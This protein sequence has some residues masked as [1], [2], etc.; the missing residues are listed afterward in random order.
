MRTVWTAIALIISSLV[1]IGLHASP[2]ALI[3]LPELV[4]VS[5]LVVIGQTKDITIVSN[6]E[7]T[8]QGVQGSWASVI[9]HPLKVIKGQTLSGDIVLNFFIPRAPAGYGSITANATRLFFLKQTGAA[10]SATFYSF[11]SLPAVIDGPVADSDALGSV[12]SQEIAV[13]TTQATPTSDKNEAIFALGYCRDPRAVQGLKRD[14]HDPSPEL[15]FEVIS[16]LAMQGDAEGVKLASQILLAPPATIP[17]YLLHNLQ[18]SIREGARNEQFLPELTALLQMKD[19]NTRRAAAEALWRMHSKQS[20][21]LL[22]R[23][24]TDEDQEVRY[25]A[26]VGLAETTGDKEH[27]PSRITFGES[28]SRY[29][30]YWKTWTAISR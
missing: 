1:G 7:T 29:L 10:Y 23:A 12:I 3:A 4:D 6:S 20:I 17:D 16:R 24:L 18:V 22:S 11:P 30:D 2:V 15:R 26:V 27:H 5:D 13:L 14:S 25:F 8:D 28:E 9:I 21:D 19:T